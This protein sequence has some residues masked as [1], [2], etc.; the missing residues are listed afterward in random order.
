MSGEI[1]S[2][3]S[4][5]R[6]REKAA[7]GGTSRQKRVVYGKSPVV[8]DDDYELSPQDNDVD[9]DVTIGIVSSASVA[10]RESSFETTSVLTQD[11][12]EIMLERL[13]SSCSSLSCL[14]ILVVLIFVHVSMTFFGFFSVFE[15]GVRV[16][17][18]EG[19]IG[20]KVAT[21]A[22]E[23]S[24]LAKDILL[25]EA[26]VT[27]D[28][29]TRDAHA[30][31]SSRS[32]F[33]DKSV[34]D[35]GR[36]ANWL[37][38]TR[39]VESSDRVYIARVPLIKNGTL[40]GL[41]PLA[42]YPGGLH[43]REP[44]DA[45]VVR[46]DDMPYTKRTYHRYSASNSDGNV[47]FSDD[48]KTVRIRIGSKAHKG[49]SLS[50]FFRKSQQD[51]NFQGGFPLQGTVLEEKFLL[52]KS[53]LAQPT[54]LSSRKVSVIR[55]STFSAIE[56]FWPRTK[57][58]GS[59]LGH[60]MNLANANKRFT[61]DTA[62]R[63][64]DSDSA[65]TPIQV[66]HTKPAP[67][68]REYYGENKKPMQQGKHLDDLIEHANIPPNLMPQFGEHQDKKGIEEKPLDWLFAIEITNSLMRQILAAAGFPANRLANFADTCQTKEMPVEESPGSPPLPP[69]KKHMKNIGKRDSESCN[70]DSDCV[71]GYECQKDTTVFHDFHEW[72]KENKEKQLNELRKTHRHFSELNLHKKVEGSESI[73]VGCFHT[74]LPSEAFGTERSR[75]FSKK[76]Y[77]TIE[78]DKL[79]VGAGADVIGGAK[80]F[81]PGLA[82]GQGYA[83]FTQNGGDLELI[84]WNLKSHDV[85][86]IP[87]K[88]FLHRRRDFYTFI[89]GE[90]ADVADH[91]VGTRYPD[92]NYRPGL[93]HPYFLR[94]RDRDLGSST[95]LPY[96]Y[97]V[98]HASKFVMYDESRRTKRGGNPMLMK[99]ALEYDQKLRDL[100][101][102]NS[103]VI[104][105][106]NNTQ[107][108]RF[109][110]CDYMS[111]SG[112]VLSFLP[113]YSQSS[114]LWLDW[115]SMWLDRFKGLKNLAKFI[116]YGWNKG[117][118]AHP[119][120]DFV[121]RIARF[122]RPVVVDCTWK[123]HVEDRASKP[124]SIDRL[125]LGA[126][127]HALYELTSEDYGGVW[128]RGDPN[129][130]RSKTIA[131]LTRPS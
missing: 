81:D 61:L 76:H 5:G 1:R 9:D 87:V 30:D 28:G 42:V 104:D 119:S 29:F 54:E 47:Q 10:Q 19:D 23:N 31:I 91:F 39:E 26:E 117:D 93:T 36:S 129:D 85:V 14:R 45:S 41:D 58:T 7:S 62:F 63:A 124:R 75:W 106:S 55:Q 128:L 6:R 115:P 4:E 125:L 3:P 37:G 121:K 90:S 109:P 105:P 95:A 99:L 66:H 84:Q 70:E 44:M 69:Q 46:Y 78:L 80:A 98:H 108:G 8:G 21:V 59:I 56:T 12:R 122:L 22:H 11:L 111:S 17:H 51:R 25:Q 114:I 15:D 92:P 100:L 16:D 27:S 13:V 96:Y 89:A 43:E 38:Q 110:D 101:P 71:A 64:L 2:G 103:Y 40:T 82:F 73:S 120:V 127:M 52:T 112:S 50:S 102:P 72:W 118:M 107:V 33:L 68:D 65:R 49:F 97:A 35:Q 53:L 77:V 94:G 74:V 60:R 86:G 20:S 18:R 113:A 57:K 130:I 123:W 131:D 116:K 32:N 24:N 83:M 67:S 79:Y 126:H 34:E 88:D 48:G